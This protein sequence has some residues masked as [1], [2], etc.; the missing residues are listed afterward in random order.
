VTGQPS[1]LDCDAAQPMLGQ[2]VAVYLDAG[3]TPAAVPSPI[4]DITAAPVL[5]GAE[6]ISAEE[7]RTVVPD[8]QEV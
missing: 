8:L 6:A 1:P 2:A 3:A 5:L 7:L 4:V